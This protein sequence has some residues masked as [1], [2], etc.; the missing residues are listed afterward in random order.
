MPRE[1]HENETEQVRGYR[2]VPVNVLLTRVPHQTV[3]G[4][5]KEF[6]C[7]FSKL[8]WRPRRDSNSRP[9]D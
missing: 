5:L 3:I 2:C 1:H 4:I 6:A 7:D 9:Q 8:T